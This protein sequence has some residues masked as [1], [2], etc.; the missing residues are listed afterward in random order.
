MTQANTLAAQAVGF[1]ARGALVIE[2]ATDGNGP[3]WSNSF[4]R[5]FVE[6][7]VL[8]RWA[9]DLICSMI[10]KNPLYVQSTNSCTDAQA[11]GARD[12][13][14]S[15]AVAAIVRSPGMLLRCAIAQREE[16]LNAGRADSEESH[17]MTA[18]VKKQ[19]YEM[20]YAFCTETLAKFGS[21]RYNDALRSKA[22]AEYTPVPFP[23]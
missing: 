8:D 16:M 3:L 21:V 15:A 18:F 9:D 22:A 6:C 4:G 10:F 5:E 17:A 2:A 13:I 7:F 11:P 12:A 14:K 1:N 23:D 20:D 19:V